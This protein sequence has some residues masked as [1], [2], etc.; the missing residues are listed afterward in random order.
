M[1]LVQDVHSHTAAGI[2]ASP[3]SSR[4][5]WC[6]VSTARL[7]ETQG[8]RGP[9]N[10]RGNGVQKAQNSNIIIQL[11][12]YL[13]CLLLL[14][15]FAATRSKMFT[16]CNL[17]R[18]LVQ[19]TKYLPVNKRYNAAWRK[20]KHSL[21]VGLHTYIYLCSNFCP[22]SG[23]P[24][25]SSPGFPQSLQANTGVVGLPPLFRILFSSQFTSIL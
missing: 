7:W 12:S 13:I 15:F 24:V 2:L 21:C 3:D 23:Y 17:Q 9:L 11:Q 20:Y 25:P 18:I 1:F 19:V 6:T 22:E 16:C 10:H 14:S 5:S 8:V 4:A